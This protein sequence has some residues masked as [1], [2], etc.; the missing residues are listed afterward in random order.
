MEIDLWEKFHSRLILF[1]LTTIRFYSNLI[2]SYVNDNFFRET[3]SLTVW[4]TAFVRKIFQIC[5]FHCA[6]VIADMRPEK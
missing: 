3:L 1:R 2:N 6:N 5:H 4:R